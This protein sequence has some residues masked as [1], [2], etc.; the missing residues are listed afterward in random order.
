M[1][2]GLNAGPCLK[3]PTIAAPISPTPC[4]MNDKSFSLVN[5]PGDTNFSAILF[6]LLINYVIIF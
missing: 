4:A 3:G 5:T 1:I 6:V 2:V